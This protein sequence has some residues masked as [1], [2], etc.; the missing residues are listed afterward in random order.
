MKPDRFLLS[1]ST[2]NKNRLCSII[3]LLFPLTR[4]CSD[5]GREGLREI[6]IVYR[7]LHF[8]IDRRVSSAPSQWAYISHEI[9]LVPKYPVRDFPSLFSGAL[10]GEM[11][12]GILGDLV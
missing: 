5:N 6:F 7:V 2:E 4:G 9:A 10:K 3:A 8:S 1:R 12:G 11:R